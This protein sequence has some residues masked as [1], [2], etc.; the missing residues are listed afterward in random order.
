MRKIAGV[1]VPTRFLLPSRVEGCKETMPRNYKGFT[2]M[3]KA[4]V[5]TKSTAK[6]SAGRKKAAPVR[7]SKS[8]TKKKK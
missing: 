3:A 2:I 5:A 8:S 4:T 6:K 1:A 7:S